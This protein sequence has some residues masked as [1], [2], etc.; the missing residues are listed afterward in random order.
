MIDPKVTIAVSPAKVPVPNGLNGADYQTLVRRVEA[1]DFTVDFRALR[2]ACMKSAQCEPRGTK[3]DLAAINRAESDHQFDKVVEIAER[4]IR[5][6]FVNI[7]AHADCVKAYEAIHDAAKSNFHLDVTAALLRSILLSGDG[8]TKETAYEV[9]S[10]REEYSTLT[11][12]GLPYV[13]SGT[14]ASA[15][16]E[17]GHRYDRWE[18]LDPKTG[19][20]VVIFFNT[21]AF[22]SKSR[23]GVN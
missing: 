3:A 16:E 13:G 20:P 10:D 5:K 7:E 17:G 8:N 21:D 2:L 9:I 4:L 1:G 12:K 6:G 14:S 11:A 22:S 19:K 18:V 15:V 23:V